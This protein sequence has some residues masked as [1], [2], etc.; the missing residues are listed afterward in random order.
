MTNAFWP[1]LTVVAGGEIGRKTR[2]SRRD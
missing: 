2:K 1:K